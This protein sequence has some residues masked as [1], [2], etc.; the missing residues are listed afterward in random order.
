MDWI[1]ITIKWFYQLM[2]TVDPT[3]DKHILTVTFWIPLILQI[4]QMLPFFAASIL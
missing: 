2:A 3:L 1:K 4:S